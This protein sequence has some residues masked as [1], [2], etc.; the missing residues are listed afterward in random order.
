MRTPAAVPQ[1][2]SYHAPPH[3]LEDFLRMLDEQRAR[4]M[5]NLINGEAAR[6][7]RRSDEETFMVG[8]AESVE[9]T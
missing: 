5:D 7:L 4:V 2:G 9:R 6:A 1:R 8:E 3:A